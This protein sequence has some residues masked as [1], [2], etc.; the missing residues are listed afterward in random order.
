MNFYSI[1]VKALTTWVVG[2]TAAIRG[3]EAGGLKAES[4]IPRPRGG[5]ASPSAGNTLIGEDAQRL[6]RAAG[7]RLS[8]DN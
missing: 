4:S 2:F 6:S 8:G 3:P 7:G 5:Q 1:A